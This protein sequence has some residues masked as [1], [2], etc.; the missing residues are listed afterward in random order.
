MGSS[1]EDNVDLAHV[2]NKKVKEQEPDQLDLITQQIPTNY[3]IDPD[4]DSYSLSRQEF[5]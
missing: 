1:E 3:L 4:R 2:N 5:E